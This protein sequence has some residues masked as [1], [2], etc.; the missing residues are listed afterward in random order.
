MPLKRF[1]LT[2]IAP[3][4]VINL[5]NACAYGFQLLLA[6]TLS[7]DDLGGFNAI[8]SGVT[9]LAAPAVVA[10]MAVTHMVAGQV[11]VFGRAG[12]HAVVALTTKVS[13]VG[14]ALL[15][16]C[17]L[18]AGPWLQL[19]FK[20]HDGAATV[21][22]AA[23]LALTSI[24]PVAAGWHQAEGRYIAMSLVLG[25]VPVL[26]LAF[27]L[28]LVLWLGMRL[29]GALVSAA[30]PCLLVFLA[31]GV[32]LWTLPLRSSP[33]S[34][35]VGRAMLTFTIPAAITTT[36]LYALFTVDMVLARALLS[37]ADSGI[38]AVA[39]VIGRIAF[40][41]PAAV[42]NA[43]YGEMKRGDDRDCS[44]KRRRFLLN[45]AG[46]G[47]V[48]LLLASFISLFAEPLILLMA[49]SS[50][51]AAVPLL[52][53]LSFAMAG[54][55]VL[56]TV[57]VLG[58][59]TSNLRGVLFVLAVGVFGFTAACL[60]FALNANAIALLLAGSIYAMLPACTLIVL[61]AI[62]AD[63]RAPERAAPATEPLVSNVMGAP[64]TILGRSA[65]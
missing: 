16:L 60:T 50:Y 25:G 23:L 62:R 11:R 58:M 47:L 45:V 12:Y 53:I 56:N 52:R 48:A 41:G 15:V 35:N 13:I 57:V 6:R 1:T 28:I 42:A 54:L 29:N 24:Y 65:R 21:E 64:N 8:L 19:L 51:Q 2:Y 31:A 20:L 61:A 59:T 43:L 32:Q 5:G 30:L 34:N 18:A 7:P 27:G 37:G 39:A 55:A 44:A 17:C 49:G 40:L 63:A 22:F 4:I 9:L 10:P 26:R 3:V 36:L 14:A 38:Y 46:V 33:L